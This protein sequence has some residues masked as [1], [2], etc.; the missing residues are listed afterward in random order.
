MHL[1]GKSQAMIKFSKK[2]PSKEMLTSFGSMLIVIKTL[3]FF[4]AFSVGWYNTFCAFRHF[5]LKVREYEEVFYYGDYD[6][7]C[8]RP[9]LSGLTLSERAARRDLRDRV[10]AFM[11]DKS[12]YS[13]YSVY[14]YVEKSKEKSDVPV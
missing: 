8:Q 9:Y 11:R 1:L 13:T 5:S 7:L 2:K 10:Y 3:F 14:E 6:S 4:F 12:Q